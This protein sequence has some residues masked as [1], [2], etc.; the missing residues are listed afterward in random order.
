MSSDVGDVA[1]A[2]HAFELA[3]RRMVKRKIASRVALV[4]LLA[5][6]IFTAWRYY[7]TDAVRTPPAGARGPATTVAAAE[8]MR[9]DF[10]VVVS[11]LGT[12]TATATAVVK[13]QVSGPLLKVRYTEGQ[14]VAAGDILAEIDPRPF[15]LAL[16]QAE[17]Q[18]QKDEALLR[19]AERDLARYESLRNKIKDGVSGQQLDT[20]KALIGQYRAAV[21]IDRALVGRAR[22]DLDYTHIA[23][24]IGG[25]IGLRQVDPGNIVQTSDPNGVAV[26]T[27]I[28]PITVI[29]SLPEA[30]LQSVLKRFRFGEKLAVVA[31]DHDRA[32]QIAR[33]A[34]Y[35]IDN[36]IDASSGTVRL[37]AE[38][39]NDDESLY[40]NQ[41][42]NAELTVETLKGVVL[43]P[44][45]A[46]QR[47]AKGPFVYAL[48]DDEKVAVRSVRLGPS[49]G[50]RAVIESGLEPGQRV[51]VEGVD[52]LRDGAKVVVTRPPKGGPSNVG[53]PAAG[54]RK[55]APAERR[56]EKTEAR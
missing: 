45:A 36:Q 12:V 29:F 54:K 50:E 11:A 19:N 35:A 28:S 53:E 38:F 2:P 26:V 4:A 6:A 49:D 3:L 17:G 31:Y 15:E 33:G 22:L 7:S 39:A 30:K 47:G 16:A 37:R 9:G 21:D 56:A 51:V 8:V 44:A 34:L 55:E 41:F 48:D 40:P 5:G 18:L 10:P 1:Q 24:P 43:A 52:R 42:V 46:L 32:E 13:P 27:R 25:R 14:E 20:Q 23:A